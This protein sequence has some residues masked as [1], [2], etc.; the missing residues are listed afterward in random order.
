MLVGMLK[1]PSYYNPN[2][3]IELTERRRN[4]VLSQMRKYDVI[5]DYLFDSLVQPL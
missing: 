5:S 4:I 2:R 3:R 1:N